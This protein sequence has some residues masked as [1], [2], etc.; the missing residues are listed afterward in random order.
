MRISMRN[1][2]GFTLIE[3]LVVIA[4]IAV[5]IALL[6]PAVQAAREAARRA[7][8][9]NNLKQI[10]LALHNYHSTNDT[11]PMGETRCSTDAAG[12]V[13]SWDGW[14]AQA[15]L[16]ASLEQT[17]L[18]NSINFNITPVDSPAAAMNNTALA[19]TINSFICPSDPQMLQTTSWGERVK[20]SYYG[21]VGVSDLSDPLNASTPVG[22]ETTGMFAFYL[23]HGIRDCTDGTSNTVAFSEGIAGTPA[24]SSGGTATYRG[25]NVQAPGGR[26]TVKPLDNAYTNMSGV[27]AD[28]ASCSAASVPGNFVASR[29]IR[30]A[31]GCGGQTLFN[32]FQT[33]NDSQYRGNGCR[34]DGAWLDDGF[35]VPAASW[36]SGGVNALFAD[37]SVKFIKSTVN[38]MTWWALGTRAGGEVVDAGSY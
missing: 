10:G 32:H 2:R 3:L 24:G 34:F 18:Y 29:N 13:N 30:W 12:D 33:P 27:M 16:L 4:I 36:H 7:Q 22:R 35:T 11:F 9:V 31:T 37:G 20:N 14:S 38:R 21:S 17:P 6:L 28:L 5:L 19:T 26:Q 8:C 1:R 25:N 23:S 15:Q